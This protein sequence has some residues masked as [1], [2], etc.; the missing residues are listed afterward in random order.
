[1]REAA[2]ISAQTSLFCTYFQSAPFFPNPS[3]YF[4][5]TGSETGQKGKFFLIF[6]QH[7]K[8]KFQIILIL[9]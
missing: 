4:T 1:M 2:H 3:K 7:L 8:R 5:K 9:F 6:T